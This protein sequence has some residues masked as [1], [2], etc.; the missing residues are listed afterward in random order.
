MKRIQLCGPELQRFG[1]DRG[2]KKIDRIPDASGFQHAVQTCKKRHRYTSRKSALHARRN[3]IRMN[4][5]PCSLVIRYGNPLNDAPFSRYANI[6]GNHG[7]CF[8]VLAREDFV[9][10]TNAS[11]ERKYRAKDA[12]RNAGNEAGK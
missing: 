12:H 3:W 4:R 11:C 2:R 10:P 5:E 1:I 7:D 6:F 8:F 9:K